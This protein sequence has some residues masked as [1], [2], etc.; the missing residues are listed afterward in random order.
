MKKLKLHNESF[1][2]I[3]SSFKDW[4]EVLG[5]ASTTVYNLP[6]HLKEFF[7][8]LE[9]NRHTRIEHITTQIVKEYYDHLSNRSNDRRGGGLSKAFLNKHQQALKKFLDYLKE[10]NTNVNFGVHL[11]GEKINYRNIKVILTQDEIKELFDACHVSHM[12]EHFQMRDRAILVLLYSCG[13]RRN[14]AVHFD[15]SDILFEKGRIYVRR[16]KNYKERF[17]PINRY[18]LQILEDYLYEARPEFLRHFQTDAFLVSNFGRR[19]NDKT[20]ADRLKVIIESTENETIISK[21]ITL[22]TL[23]HSIATHLL[24]NNVPMKS[25]STFLGHSSLE[26][27]QIYTHIVSQIENEEI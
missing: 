3:L 8:Y 7:Y 13:L 2:T 1:I 14:E 5:Y 11:R 27:T 22:H 17:V 9:R 6:N 21:N 18:N 20:M 25:I 12:S 16:G 15:A 10:H 23:R 4:L 24:Q 26:S 19:I